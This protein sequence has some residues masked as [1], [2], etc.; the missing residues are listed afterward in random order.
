M[1]LSSRSTCGTFFDAELPGR[2]RDAG[3]VADQDHL[4]ILQARP[5]LDGIALDDVDMRV[6]ERLG[7]RKDRSGK[8]CADS[9]CRFQ[10]SGDL[11]LDPGI[12]ALEAFFEG[13]LRFPFEH[14]AQAGVIRIA[15]AHAHRPGDMLDGDL[16]PGNLGN[17]VG[18]LVDG[19]H[20]VRAQVQRGDVIG[21]HQA[22]DAFQAIVNVAEGT[23]LLAI[24]PHLDLVVAGQLGDGDLAGHGCRSFFAAAIP[25]AL[26]AEDV[27]ETDDAGLQAVILA[28]VGAQAFHDQFFP[29][30]GILRHG[31]IG[32]LFLERDHIGFGLLVFG[33]DAGR[34]SVEVALD[35]VDAGGFER[36]GI[37]QRVV[38]QDLR[39]VRRK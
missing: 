16:D 9:C 27:V 39:M 10:F 17:H 34:G 15:A 22:V 25:G 37:D 12:G 1:P 23:G 20:A 11:L 13:E 3:F 38:V 30:I 14:F 5:G 26:V 32:I 31:R 24:A 33:V 8:P 29:A 18:Q 19:H 4:H 35:A 28:V 7:S 2:L 6:G 21:T 36:V